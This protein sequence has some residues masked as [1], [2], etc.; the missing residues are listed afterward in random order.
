M[1]NIYYI[2][3]GVFME[4]LQFLT[5]FFIEQ[6]KD[7][8]ITP[9]LCLLKDNCFDLR[10]TFANLSPQTAGWIFGTGDVCVSMVRS[11]GISQR[12]RYHHL[13]SLRS[14]D[15]VS[16][17]PA[18]SGCWLRI[19]FCQCGAMVRLSMWFCKQARHQ[20]AHN[21]APLPRYRHAQLG[22]ALQKENCAGRKRQAPALRQPHTS[23]W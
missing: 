4:I 13:Q 2:V 15:S 7:S 20:R 18:L 1:F 21:S 3:S 12:A 5:N 16:A 10:K 14:A 9:I 23:R 17:Q 6:F 11:C 19:S 22:R 8:S